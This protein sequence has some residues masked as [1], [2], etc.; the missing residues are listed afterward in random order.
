MKWLWVNATADVT[1]F[2]LLDGRSAD[3][4]LQVIIQSTKGVVATG[5]YC[6]YNWLASRWRQVCW[7]HLARDFQ[8]MVERG[9]ESKE[10]GRALLKRVKRLF[11]LWHKVATATWPRAVPD[12]HQACAAEGEGVT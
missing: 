11:T 2:H 1:A 8:A 9:G 6:S 3:A 10:T 7:A 4:A 5:R 12:R